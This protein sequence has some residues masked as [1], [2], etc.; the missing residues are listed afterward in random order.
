MV[1]G[2]PGAHNLVMQLKKPD[3][4]GSPRLGLQLWDYQGKRGLWSHG[5]A[6]GGDRF[7]AP[8]AHE[9]WHD[10]VVHFKVTGESTGFYEVY[11]DGEI[12]KLRDDISVLRQGAELA[13]LKTGLYRNGDEIPGL[14]E[15]RLDSAALGT[16]I[17]QVAVE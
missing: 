5:G 7:L 12:V 16:S 6:M 11:L 2:R 15:I 9:Q 1:Y 13:Y 14:S 4:E 3:N 8:I 17:D 10:V